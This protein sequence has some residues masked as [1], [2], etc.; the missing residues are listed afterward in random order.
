M[1][2]NRKVLIGGLNSDDTDFVVKE[3]EYINAEN[4][5]WGTTDNGSV[6]HMEPIGSNTV[7]PYTLPAG[8]NIT[9]GR[10][11]DETRQRIIRLVWNSNGDHGIYA[12]DKIANV[13]RVILMDSD[14]TGGLGFQKNSLVNG[15]VVIGDIL[16]WLEDSENPPR[17]VNTEAAIKMNDGTYTTDV[18]P[19]TTPLEAEVITVIRKPPEFPLLAG[20]FNDA[21]ITVN[22]ISNF[23][24]QFAARYVFR[25]GEVSVLSTISNLINYNTITEDSTNLNHVLINWVTA[26]HINQDVQQ[27]DFC[28]RYGDSGKFYVIKSWNK[29]N[30]DEALEIANHNASILG[31]QYKF[32]NDKVGIALDDAYSIKPYDIV[33]RKAKTLAAATDR[34][35]LGNNL[36]DF[37][38]P[39][40]TSLILTQVTDTNPTFQNPVFKAGGTYKTGIRFL[41]EFKRVLGNVV[42]NDTNDVKAQIPD[43]DYAESVYVKY[44]TWAVSNTNAVDEIPAAAK[45]YQAVITKNLRTR[46]FLQGK[47]KNCQYAI[48]DAVTGVI[49]YSTTYAVDRYG[50]AFDMSYIL[51]E[52][53]GYTFEEGDYVKLY[54]SGSATIFNLPVLGQDGENLIVKLDNLGSFAVQPDIIVEIYTPYRESSSEPYFATGDVF[55]VVN[56]GTSGREYSAL[57]GIIYGDVYLYGRAIPSS[58]YVAENMSTN[59]KHWREWLVN[60]GEPNFI[61]RS[62]EKWETNAI[63]W[64]NT[65]IQGTNTNGLSTF[66]AI[67]KKILP[68]E[69]GAIYKLILANKIEAQG[70]V[71]LAICTEETASLYLG[72]TQLVGSSTNA[73][74]ATSGNVIGTINVLKGSHGTLNP[75]SVVEHR[76]NVYWFDVRNGMFIE[77]S[78]N[79]LDVISDFKIRRFAR[80]FADKYKSISTATIEGY[81]SRPF[82][83]GIVDKYHNELM[84]S[85]PKVEVGDPNPKGYIPDY[86]FSLEY[87]YDFYDG[88]GKTIVYKIGAQKWIGAYSH[89]AEMFATIGSDLYSMKDGTL[90][91]HNDTASTN[92]FYGVQYDSKVMLLCNADPLDVKTFLNLGIEAN[93]MPSF[94]HMRS[95]YPYIQSSDLIP[96]LFGI[97]EGIYVAS[98]LRDRVSPQYTP[99]H[100]FPVEAIQL[101]GDRMRNTA[102]RIMLQWKDADLATPFANFKMI[103][104]GYNKSLG[105]KA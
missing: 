29:D 11:T 20:K 39:A 75:E 16:Y 50:V 71:M 42:T 69:M 103:D 13:T 43:R 37:T 6:G 38:T 96:A 12:Y 74:I 46:F 8:T 25:D 98:I 76:G 82:I 9:I 59:S 57:G 1:Q 61:I 51:S 63:A 80:L 56:P 78:D 54:V 60:L 85:I 7:I 35:F 32:L 67:D 24:G 18:I 101:I 33:P 87:P 91:K 23:A 47:S 17:K 58:S 86:I 83:F 10:T 30:A 97:K 66:D 95:E 27:V 48:K 21:G 84:W 44:I 62:K 5:R 49:S 73:F 19:Y 34:L 93:I 72:E 2:K 40:L 55:N 102:L 88:Y 81:G 15:A 52:G 22:N 28:V 90:W 4:I 104:I 68:F 92:N 99:T 53:L 64:S 94:V 89:K 77:Y 31:L 105:Q 65:L 100:L 79:G 26:I 45:Y 14:V 36:I 70:N 3:T 41:D